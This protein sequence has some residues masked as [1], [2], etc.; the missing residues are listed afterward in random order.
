MQIAQ[1][2]GCA[3]IGFNLRLLHLCRASVVDQKLNSDHNREERSTKPKTAAAR[4]NSPGYGLKELP[5]SDRICLL[6]ALLIQQTLSLPPSGSQLPFC[7]LR[8]GY[9]SRVSFTATPSSAMTVMTIQSSMVAVFLLAKRVNSGVKP[10]KLRGDWPKTYLPE[11]RSGRREP[12]RCGWRSRLKNTRH[13]DTL[14]LVL[15]PAVCQSR[16]GVDMGCIPQGAG[17]GRFPASCRQNST[18]W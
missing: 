17:S 11:K 13:P 8:P 3:F 18:G 1:Q 9:L 6:P 4:K 15:V 16:D 5:P 14:M 10:E 2:R 12:R 7:R